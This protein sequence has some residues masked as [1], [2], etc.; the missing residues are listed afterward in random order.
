M[1]TTF[2]S[3]T[4]TEAES[5]P[6]ALAGAFFSIVFF[7]GAGF[8]TG[9]FFFWL[10]ES[11]SVVVFFDGLVFLPDE[12]LPLDAEVDEKQRELDRVKLQAK[13]RI[14]DY[15]ANLATSKAKYELEVDDLELHDLLGRS[16]PARLAAQ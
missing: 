7:G 14:A 2:L 9:F 15:E 11:S 13:A 3:A 12:S 6:L 5:D 1:T 10:E 16:D 8:L 4:L